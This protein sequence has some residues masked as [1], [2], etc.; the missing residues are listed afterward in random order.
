MTICAHL[1]TV[2]KNGDDYKQ[3]TSDSQ[4]LREAQESLNLLLQL[5]DLD[6]IPSKVR[7]SFSKA[8]ARLCRKTG[9]YPE[10]LTLNGLQQIGGRV[11]GGGFG[12]VSI[13]LLRGTKVS[14][15]TPRVP[16][17]E[18]KRLLKDFSREIIIWSQLSHPNVLPL[19]GI[20][21]LDHRDT[22]QA[23]IVSPWME[24][25]NLLKFLTT[26]SEQVNQS[27]LI[28]DI[29]SGLQYLHEQSIIHGDL[30]ELNVLVTPSLR[31]CI[32]DFGLSTIA[33]SQMTTSSSS[34]NNAGTLAWKA[35][36]TIRHVG[37]NTQ[38]SD[39]YSFAC[40]CYE[41]FTG[42]PPFC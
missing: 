35:P 5:L 37:R 8:M 30:K 31:A 41:V 4:P 14:I 15:K 38:K 27:S 22:S 18:L 16:Q 19:Y 25:G 24:H 7:S 36:E 20:Y 26:V 34:S 13:G 33:A 21:Y 6:D 1:L 2:I 32:M 3:L 17:W 42:K 39:M 29:A 40:V 28:L 9:L 23:C 10:C 11:D 12:D